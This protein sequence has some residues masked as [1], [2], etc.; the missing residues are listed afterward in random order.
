MRQSF[1]FATCTIATIE[2]LRSLN[3]YANHP[4]NRLEPRSEPLLLVL[5]VL[6]LVL[7]FFAYPNWE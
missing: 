5:I 7:V 3:G 1:V 2:T 4:G 6:T